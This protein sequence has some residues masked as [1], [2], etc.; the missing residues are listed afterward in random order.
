MQDL[1]DKITEAGKTHTDV[2]L[3]I[4]VQ[5]HGS[6]PRETGAKMLVYP[7]GSIAGT[8]GGGELEKSVIEEAL[9]V[10]KSGKPSLFRHDLLHQHNMCCGGS[11]EI[12]IEPV[13]KKKRLYIFGA[14]HTGHALARFATALDFEIYII[15]DRKDYL[16]QITAEGVNKMHLHYGQALPLLPFDDH[17]FI[18][19]MTYSHP[20]DR[21]ILSFCLKK[22]HAYLGMIGS[23]RKV[24]MTKKMFVEGKIASAEELDKV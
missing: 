21:D 3:C 5:T 9:K 24:E 8:I 14:G 1:F 19:I 10:L 18:T 13:M 16:D 15:D 2:A 6:T 4:I 11:V 12:Y 17:T 20:F 22:P 23:M 7:D